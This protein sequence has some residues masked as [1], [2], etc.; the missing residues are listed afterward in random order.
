MQTR[1][2]YYAIAGVILS[3]ILSALL[4]GCASRTGDDS[5]SPLAKGLAGTDAQAASKSS[6]ESSFS[7][8]WE[9]T[10]RASCASLL[11]RP[12]RCNALQ[13]V[14]ITVLEGP[15][16]KYSGS[17]TCAYGNMDCFNQNTTG[18]VV[19][20][21]FAGARMNVRVMMPDAMSC[22]YTGIN[23]NQNINGGYSCYQGGGLV[24]EGSWLARRSY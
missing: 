24:E 13:N 23:V 6:A 15:N 18:K 20:V 3:T 17:Y 1:Q 14:T 22:I 11:Y 8:V 12:G 21:S 2:L 5:P 7:G 4:L 10:T 16:G 9:G 19:A